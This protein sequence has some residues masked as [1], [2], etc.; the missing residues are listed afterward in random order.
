[1]V[2]V[3]RK[4]KSAHM[5]CWAGS[6][7]AQTQEWCPRRANMVCLA[8]PAGSPGVPAQGTL[9]SFRCTIGD[10]GNGLLYRRGDMSSCYLQNCLDRGL[11]TGALWSGV[12]GHWCFTVYPL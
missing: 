2:L 12:R 6:L 5:M 7:E 4:I 3:S 10:R 11:E 1:M 8:V 9:R